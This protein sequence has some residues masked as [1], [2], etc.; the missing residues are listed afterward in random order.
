MDVKIGKTSVPVGVKS[1]KKYAVFL[2]YQNKRNCENHKYEIIIVGYPLHLGYRN[3]EFRRVIE[4]ESNLAFK[5]HNS[6]CVLY[7]SLTILLNYDSDVPSP[8]MF[9]TTISALPH[10]HVLTM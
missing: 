1:S 5:N 6:S 2:K 4:G 8:E 3:F 10:S 9:Y 7:M